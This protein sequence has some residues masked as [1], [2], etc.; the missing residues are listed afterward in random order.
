LLTTYMPPQMVAAVNP[1]KSPKAEL[2]IEN[3]SG[4]FS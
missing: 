2:F 3:P 4:K 1:A